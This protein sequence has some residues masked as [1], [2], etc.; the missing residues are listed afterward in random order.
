MGKSRWRASLA[1]TCKGP[2]TTEIDKEKKKK[3]RK[4]KTKDGS[5]KKTNRKKRTK[6]EERRRGR[7]QEKER[8][9]KEKSEE[10]N[11]LCGIRL[12]RNNTP[13][14]GTSH[15]TMSSLKSTPAR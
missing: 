9:K 10:T 13:P 4:K 14:N 7:I 8:S 12:L 11:L 6:E 2:I 15:K 1:L 3:K 5:E